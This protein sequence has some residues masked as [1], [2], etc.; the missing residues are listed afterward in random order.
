MGV[1]RWRR[2][3]WLGSGC[4]RDGS[5]GPPTGARHCMS[6]PIPEPL[7]SFEDKWASVHRELPLA[8]AFIDGSERALHSAFACLTCEIGA[9]VFAVTDP[10][11]AAVKL[12]WWVHELGRLAEGKP[13][14]P[15][16]RILVSRR[17]VLA[18]TIPA[19]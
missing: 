15:L 1:P 2:S 12:E 14:H 11:P 7:A 5:F 16:T 19:C 8:L 9:A 3:A 17:D 4:D 18:T 13:E 10:E 6:A